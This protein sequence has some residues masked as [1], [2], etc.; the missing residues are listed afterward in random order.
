V[1]HPGVSC[2]PESFGFND[3]FLQN[4]TLAKLEAMTAERD[5][6]VVCSIGLGQ[7]HQSG[8]DVDRYM[9]PRFPP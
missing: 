1:L 5:T 7:S 4:R 8:A 6:T 9:D 3:R 2:E